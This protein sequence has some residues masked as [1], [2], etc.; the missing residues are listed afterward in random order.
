MKFLGV[1]IVL[2]GVLGTVF[3]VLAADSSRD[4]PLVIAILGTIITVTVITT[5]LFKYLGQMVAEQQSTSRD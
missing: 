2:V 3:G 1:S 5:Q 4:G